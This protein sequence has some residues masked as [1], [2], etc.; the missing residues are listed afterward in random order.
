MRTW[1]SGWESDTRPVPA[2]EEDPVLDVLFAN[3]TVF[4]V[5]LLGW[6]VHPWLVPALLMLTLAGAW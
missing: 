4:V 3:G 2:S 5:V 1:D 6:V